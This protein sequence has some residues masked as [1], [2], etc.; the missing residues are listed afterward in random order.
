MSIVTKLTEKVDA[1]ESKL[2]TLE[3]EVVTLYVKREVKG[4]VL[5]TS[6]VIKAKNLKSNP[7]ASIWKT[8]SLL[9]N[10]ACVQN[11]DKEALNALVTSQFVVKAPYQ[12]DKYSPL[13]I[14][15]SYGSTGELMRLCNVYFEVHCFCVAHYCIICK[16]FAV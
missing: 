3:N 16:W 9:R 11:T 15:I 1:L 2:V 12:V 5:P 10:G 14:R 4:D 8:G 13:D 7:D 6:S